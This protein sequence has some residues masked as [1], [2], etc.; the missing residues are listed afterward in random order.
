MSPFQGHTLEE[1]QGQECHRL[2][3]VQGGGGEGDWMG[4]KT[5]TWQPLGA[6]SLRPLVTFPA[7]G[8]LR[9][10]ALNPA[11][12]CGALD[13]PVLF[14]TKKQAQRLPGS[15]QTCSQW[16]LPLILT[17]HPRRPWGQIPA[18][19]PPPCDHGQA[20]RM[21]CACFPVCTTGQ[22]QCPRHDCGIQ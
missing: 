4:L 12:R 9:V 13:Q 2:W 16:G 3:E 21:L 1:Q 19:T 15:P 20:A 14:Q 22:L 17:I 8:S 10:Q 11:P 5:R 6:W 18:P 7:W